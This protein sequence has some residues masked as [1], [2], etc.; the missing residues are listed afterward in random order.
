MK[1]VE[2]AQNK[3][4]NGLLRVG[5]KIFSSD[6]IGLIIALAAIIVVF[7]VLTQG[8]Y[9]T[10]TNVINILISSAIVGLAMIGETFLM[11]TGGIDLS[12]GSVAAFSGV[13]VALLLTNG[14]PFLLALLITVAVGALGGFLN[15]LLINKLKFIPFIATLAAMSVFRGAAFIICGGKAIFLTNKTFLKMGAGRFLGIPIP[16]L[17][18]L[19]LFIVFWVVLSRTRFGRNVYMVGGNETA[20]RLAGINAERTRMVLYMI[21]GALAALGGCL[22]AARMSSG[23]PS[24]CEGLEFDA[25][26]AAVLGGVAMTG[27]V[28]TMSGA[29]IGLMILQGF[30]NGLM[31]MNVPSF[32]QT[33]SRGLILIAALA[34]DFIRTQQRKKKSI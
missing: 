11:I 25:V 23:Q 30:N 27:G 24:A 34:F 15:S 13:L 12:P 7:N 22:M 4:P 14:V 3:Q 9:F 26:T 33:V 6:K 10:S 2:A 20:A 18:F 32:W 16:V 17:V 29:L 19:V 28:G 1:T 8:K 31:M 5:G 21:S